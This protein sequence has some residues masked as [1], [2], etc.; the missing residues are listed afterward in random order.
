MLDKKTFIEGMQMLV[1]TFPNW[2]VKVEDK[3]TMETWYKFFEDKEDSKFMRM[4]RVYIKKERS[5]PTVAGLMD[6]YEVKLR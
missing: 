3:H 2:M 6:Y 1:M 4:I 5:Y